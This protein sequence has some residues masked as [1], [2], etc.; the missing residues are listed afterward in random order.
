MDSDHPGQYRGF[1][2]GCAEF[3]ADLAQK[4]LHQHFK[5]ADYQ[6]SEGLLGTL[7]SRFE[8]IIKNDPFERPLKRCAWAE[9][10]LCEALSHLTR[11]GSSTFLTAAPTTSAY[12][13]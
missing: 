6:S 12:S 1:I 3:E 5:Y 11:S 2:L 7:R 10:R 9:L 13:I 8:S 4:C